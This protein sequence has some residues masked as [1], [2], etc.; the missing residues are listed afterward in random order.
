MRKKGEV[1][2]YRVAYT[3]R[4]PV[5]EMGRCSMCGKRGLLGDGLCVSCWDKAE[6]YLTN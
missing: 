2:G 1:K 3:N 4:K 6:V 5:A